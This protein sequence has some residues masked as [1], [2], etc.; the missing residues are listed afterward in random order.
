M[1]KSFLAPIA[2]A[3]FFLLGSQLQA[4]E[5]RRVHVGYDRCGRAVYE[6]VYVGRPVYERCAPASYSYRRSRSYYRPVYHAPR[7]TYR[8]G[9]RDCS[10][11][12][13]VSF[14]FSR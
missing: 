3:A 1:N 14:S 10:P 11:R 12:F 8:S 13:G 5:Y 2:A 7:V 9:Y 4:G 6:T